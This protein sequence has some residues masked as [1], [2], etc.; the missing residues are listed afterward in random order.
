MKKG[1]ARG[2]LNRLVREIFEEIVGR[3]LAGIF[4]GIPRLRVGR[5][6]GAIHEEILETINEEFH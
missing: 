5:I 2:I 1:I 4:R 3:I 6:F